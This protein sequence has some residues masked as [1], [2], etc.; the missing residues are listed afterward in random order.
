MKPHTSK[1]VGLDFLPG[2]DHS[3]VIFYSALQG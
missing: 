3:K 1:V 2:A